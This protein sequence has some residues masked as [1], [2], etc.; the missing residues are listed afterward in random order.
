MISELFDAD[1]WRPV[2]GFTDFTDITYHR[3]VDTRNGQ[4]GV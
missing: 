3:A 4:G 2:S 1:A